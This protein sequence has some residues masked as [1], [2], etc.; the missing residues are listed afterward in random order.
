MNP[1]VS[2]EPLVVI[3][4]DFPGDSKS[5]SEKKGLYS[6]PLTPGRSGHQDNKFIFSP[7]VV[8][9]PT[10]ASNASGYFTIP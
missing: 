1:Y 5:V 7:L 9:M 8:L 4:R 10:I 2:I 6:I 3:L